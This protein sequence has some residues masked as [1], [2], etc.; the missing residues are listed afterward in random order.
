ML[1]MLAVSTSN[2]ALAEVRLGILAVAMLYSVTFMV[3]T[4]KL[5]M[6]AD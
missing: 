5:A 2:C 6:L 4:V 3:P 1:A